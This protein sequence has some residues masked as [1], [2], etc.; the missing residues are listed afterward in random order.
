MI[1]S[2]ERGSIL[3]DKTCEYN[4]I[5]SLIHN[6]SSLYG[7]NIIVFKDRD[8]NECALKSFKGKFFKSLRNVK[9]LYY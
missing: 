1:I 3:N 5:Q 9:K 7:S 2:S 6:S 8:G 4:D